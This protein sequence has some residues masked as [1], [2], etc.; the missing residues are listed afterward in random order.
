MSKIRKCLSVT[1]AAV[2]MFTSI[3]PVFAEGGEEVTLVEE[4]PATVQAEEVAP[5]QPMPEEL[6]AEPAPEEEKPVAEPEP[7]AEEQPVAETLVE[8]P[9]AEE[10]PIAEP[11]P[12]EQPVAEP[13]PAEEEQPVAEAP[14]ENP[15]EEELPIAEPL[16]EEVQ[17]VA[18]QEPVV[19]EQPA[20]EAPAEE[21]VGE[22]NPVEDI[23]IDVAI[24]EE[25]VVN[26]DNAITAKKVKA[27]PD[28][29]E[30]GIDNGTKTETTVSLSTGMSLDSMYLV[31]AP[32]G[33]DL[34]SIEFQPISGGDGL[35][36]TVYKYF[37]VTYT[38]EKGKTHNEYPAMCLAQS[39]SA[40]ETNKVTGLDMEYY[41]F[42][43]AI[44]NADAEFVGEYRIYFDKPLSRSIEMKFTV[45][46]KLNAHDLT[47]GTMTVTAGYSKGEASDS[48]RLG[49][50]KYI[51][52]A[53]VI[54]EPAAEETVVEEPT[55]EAAP[56]TAEI[57]NEAETTE[58][59]QM[60]A[61]TVEEAPMNEIVPEAV[62]EE[63]VQVAEAIEEVPTE[64]IIPE[65][66]VETTALAA[67][68]MEETPVEETIPEA[69]TEEPAP[70]VETVEGAPA[71]ESVFANKAE[72]K[73]EATPEETTVI[74]LQ[75]EEKTQAE[76]TAETT[77]QPEEEKQETKSEEKAEAEP[78][79]TDVEE[80]TAGKSMKLGAAPSGKL[81]VTITVQDSVTEEKI[82]GVKVMVTTDGDTIEFSG[83]SDTNGKIIGEVAPGTYTITTV[84]DTIPDGYN[85]PN[86][87]E[88][89]TIE[90]ALSYTVKLVP[91]KDIP[92]NI[93][94]TFLD[95]NSKDP[96]ENVGVKILNSE[97][98]PVCSGTSNASGVYESEPLELGDYIM[99]LTSVPEEYIDPKCSANVQITTKATYTQTI[100]LTAKA[101]ATA[102][103]TVKCYTGEEKKPVENVAFVVL[104]ASSSEYT[105]GKTTS[106]GTVEFELPLGKYTVKSTDCPDNY[107]EPA[108]SQELEI[109][110]ETSKKIEVE[111]VERQIGASLEVTCVDKHTGD[112][113]ENVIIAICDNND[114]EV[115]NEP[116]DSEGVVTA[117]QLKLGKY[118]IYVTTVP[119]NY[120]YEGWSTEYEFDK[121]QKYTLKIELTQKSYVR[122]IV[123]VVCKDSETLEA[124]EDVEIT[125]RDYNNGDFFTESTGTE[126]SVSTELPIGTYWVRISDVPEEYAAINW[127]QE[128]DVKDETKHTYN[129][130]LT[131]ITGATLKIACLDE[132]T[133]A[134]VPNVEFTILDSN[135]EEA[136][137]GTTGQ[138][139]IFISKKL[140]LGSYTIKSTSTPVGYKA[141][142][143]SKELNLDTATTYT[144]DVKVTPEELEKA[145]IEV[146]CTDEETTEP[147][148]NVPF[149]VY[150]SKSEEYFVGVSNDQGVF[151]VDEVANDNYTIIA[152]GVP[153]GYKALEY[154]QEVSVTEAIKYPFTVTLTPE[155]I[156]PVDPEIETFT[157]LQFEAEEIKGIPSNKY[158]YALKGYELA[159]TEPDYQAGAVKFTIKEVAPTTNVKMLFE[160]TV[161]SYRVVAV[162]KEGIASVLP[163][164]NDDETV[165]DFDSTLLPAEE[166]ETGALPEDI[167]FL[168]LYVEN[169]STEFAVSEFTLTDTLPDTFT[170]I[171]YTVQTSVY[172]QS[173]VKPCVEETYNGKIVPGEPEVTLTLTA[174]ATETDIA[175][176]V[177]FAGELSTVVP[178]VFKSSVIDINVP[179]NFSPMLINPGKWANYTGKI[180]ISTINVNGIENDILTV[181]SSI[182][183]AAQLS[184][185]SVSTIRLTPLNELGEGFA[186]S[187]LA[188]SGCFN[189]SGTAFITMSFDGMISDVNEYTTE[190]DKCYVTVAE[191]PAT[192]TPEP[193]A[194][195]TPTPEPTPTPTPTPEPTKEPGPVNPPTIN[196]P[197]PAPTAVPLSIDT[198][199]IY[200]NEGTIKYGDDAVFNI[201]NLNAHG[202]KED[203][204]YV[205]HLMIPTGVQVRSLTFPKF[206]GSMKVSLVYT[207]GTSTLGTYTGAETVKLKDRE[208][209]NLKYISFQMRGVTDVT[210][211]GDVTL[212]V[213]NVSARDRVA[214]LQA[215]LS[216]RDAK[217]AVL[218][219]EYD[220]YNIALS[221][222]TPTETT[223]P[224]PTDEPS[225]NR[226]SS[227]VAKGGEVSVISETYEADRNPMLL[228]AENGEKTEDGKYIPHEVIP[229]TDT[230]GTNQ[231]MLMPYTSKPEVRAIVPFDNIKWSPLTNE[232]VLKYR[233]LARINYKYRL[234]NYLLM[235]PDN[236]ALLLNSYHIVK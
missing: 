163:H 70:V 53:P 58:E 156:T 126:G 187:E 142:N 35:T 106:D 105:D 177:Y 162:S 154:L 23:I 175:E 21:P 113:V 99:E 144:S 29:K 18:E 121:E 43:N 107:K 161:D 166:G 158:A 228:M 170:E 108:V 174:D 50:A 86:V 164:T 138:D 235:S 150:D 203:E 210:L 60:A 171:N 66:V 51:Y 64:E 19:E 114:S 4:Q 233:E 230:R 140:P 119:G 231:P 146:T 167:W 147:V 31:I 1:L 39:V 205:V 206:G 132:K 155:E 97:K 148:A 201:R 176:T 67:E 7:I 47:Q 236:M 223:T 2:L 234:K 180:K 46:G 128:F 55:I 91:K 129:I 219:Q 182:A 115:F 61:E 207:S 16:P 204:Y 151:A 118:T 139:G 3:A 49:T 168:W 42:P 52:E 13:E 76:E 197:T 143:V 78:E 10:I 193:T 133:N 104:D 215:I 89:I 20:A 134:P 95:K 75:P 103:V 30:T 192:P 172:K 196:T 74:E 116:T 90:Q 24:E 5:E 208:G 88:E 32:N 232:F 65:T 11:M 56:E 45:N 98:S 202:V 137:K 153:S 211:N 72:E 27:N 127:E 181:D 179:K 94:L 85:D 110:D 44:P 9:V 122:S 83:E 214:T 33:L 165:V 141:L 173:E 48:M 84:S 8:E 131:K 96:I 25:P 157:A 185:E 124:V 69:V 37:H 111:M 17:P 77:E 22:E 59:V 213:K 34:K 80:I 216:I 57:V 183:A 221:G 100:D 117:E 225:G 136:D 82:Q 26:L 71:E 191:A 145:I 217:T 226:K 159:F 152:T 188:L 160:G 135:S 120:L 222:P 125:I 224:A 81:E 62:A 198:P 190:S 194:T 112:K 92:A 227:N 212:M 186:I 79:I 169:P 40:S 54:E 15:V 38:D 218:A 109:T 229:N 73:I 93:V 199:V 149:I 123:E 184:G 101:D 14:A 102:V 200:A 36:Y 130:S 68:T 195:P 28:T 6:V 209:M 189:S 220:K 178:A 12:E 87:D 63:P 41:E